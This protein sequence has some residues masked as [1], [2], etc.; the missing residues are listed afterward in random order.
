[1]TY[2]EDQIERLEVQSRN[3][4]AENAALTRSLHLLQN[5]LQLATQK[6]VT[7]TDAVQ[8]RIDSVSL[9]KY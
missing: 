4:Q 2:L 3:A 8:S 6:S 1:V 7:A 9:H 5:Q